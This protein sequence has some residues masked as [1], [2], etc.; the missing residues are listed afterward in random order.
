MTARVCV[1]IFPSSA[2]QDQLRQPRSAH[3]EVALVCKTE[4]ESPE[5]VRGLGGSDRAVLA[6]LE[7]EVSEARL[8]LVEIPVERPIWV[9]GTLPGTMAEKRPA[10]RPTSSN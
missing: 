2:S 1:G 6:E 5:S 9:N 8:A 3:G 4:A 7:I 10:P